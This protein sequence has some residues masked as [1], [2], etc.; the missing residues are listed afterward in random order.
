MVENRVKE[1]RK[2]AKLTLA[3]LAE[4]SGVPIST[5]GDIELGA[6]PRVITAIRIARVLGVNVELL[7]PV[8]N[9]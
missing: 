3:E 6:E 4:R 5:I 1:Y 8:Q 2:A 9:K 7:W